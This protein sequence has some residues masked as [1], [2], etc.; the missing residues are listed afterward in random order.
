MCSVWWYPTW[1]K[2]MRP[3][4]PS[5]WSTATNPQPKFLVEEIA[6]PAPKLGE[7]PSCWQTTLP[8]SW[9]SSVCSAQVPCNRERR[10]WQ[11][12][13]ILLLPNACHSWN[14]R[15]FLYFSKCILFLQQTW[16]CVSIC[17]ETCLACSQDLFS[18]K[19]GI[20]LVVN[21][22]TRVQIHPSICVTVMKNMQ[23][24]KSVRG[25]RSSGMLCAVESYLPDVSGRH[26]AAIFCGQEFRL[27][28]S[29]RCDQ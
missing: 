3:W 29:R 9:C 11:E 22:E 21:Q 5:N 14:I 19:S 10:R 6:N 12:A 28:D 18:S 20:F 25:L 23:Q 27:L 16:L 26:I 7:S 4:V 24:V 13:E 17:F 15:L 2:I 1:C 8:S